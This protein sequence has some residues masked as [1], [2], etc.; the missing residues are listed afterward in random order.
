MITQQNLTSIFSVI[1]ENPDI[2]SFSNYIGVKEE[3]IWIPYFIS[4]IILNPDKRSAVDMLEKSP[5]F[6]KFC[7]FLKIKSSKELLTL[8]KFFLNCTTQESIN[9]LIEIA[10]PMMR[11]KDVINIFT[12]H[13]PFNIRSFKNISNSDV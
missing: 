10:F 6:E 2:N 5:F 7:K 8:L 9:D 1:T 12:L 3:K 13:Q 4:Q 11:K